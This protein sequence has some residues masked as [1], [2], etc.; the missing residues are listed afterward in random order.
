MTLWSILSVC[1]RLLGLTEWAE[2]AWQLHEAKVQGKDEQK[3][4]DTKASYDLT[5]E[6][7]QAASDAPKTRQEVDARLDEGKI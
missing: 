4:A 6:Q 2:R 3:A 5:K 7:A 1:A